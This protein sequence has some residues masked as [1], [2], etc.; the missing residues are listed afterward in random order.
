MENNNLQ[1]ILSTMIQH[2]GALASSNQQILLKLDEVL[3]RL[4]QQEPVQV[5][6][7]AQETVQVQEPAQETVQVQ[8]QEPMP[9]HIPAQEQVID[10]QPTSIDNTVAELVA[11]SNETNASADDIIQKISAELLG[12][13]GASADNDI[14][15]PTGFAA[16]AVAQEPVKTREQCIEEI[17]AGLQFDPALVGSVLQTTNSGVTDP[18]VIAGNLGTSVETVTAILGL[19]RDGLVKHITALAAIQALPY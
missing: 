5:Q 3:V 11:S 12:E 15:I 4:Q 1:T 6:E 17:T 14:T 16:Q 13:G 8:A 9:V 18:M 19:G 7:P 2:L 10:V